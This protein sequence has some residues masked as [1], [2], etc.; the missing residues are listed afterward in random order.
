MSWCSP[1]PICCISQK[2]KIFSVVGYE[3]NQRTLDS[4]EPTFLNLSTFISLICDFAL[5]YC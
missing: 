1:F 3:Y 4:V 5:S 2:T